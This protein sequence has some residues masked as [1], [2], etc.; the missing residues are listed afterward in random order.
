LLQPEPAEEVQ[1][2]KLK[3]ASVLLLALLCACA[4]TLSVHRETTDSGKTEGVDGI[5]FYIQKAHCVHETV[6]LETQYQLKL[7]KFAAETADEGTKTPAK[8]PKKLGEWEKLIS[9]ATMHT[10]DFDSLRSLIGREDA[11]DS[12]DLERLLVKLPVYD[13]KKVLDDKDHGPMLVSNTN[14]PQVYVDYSTTYFLN[15]KRP[16]IGTSSVNA[17][18]RP[19]G[20]L[21]KG[22]AETK[23]ETITTLLASVPLKEALT[24]WLKLDSAMY[25][26]MGLPASQKS[27]VRYE[28]SIEPIQYLHT[29]SA[30]TADIAPSCK[31]CKRF[32]FTQNNIDTLNYTRTKLSGGGAKAPDK[33]D[34]SIKVTGEITLPKSD[35]KSD[36]K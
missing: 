13:F 6:W 25:R 5:P 12:K 26:P 7:T 15:S 18:T 36:K 1:I 2:M 11:T 33:D 14:K 9:E 16:W 19:D 30:I 17:E 31:V 21:G 20:T 28:L 32:E 23:D 24:K 34:S 10:S 8:P 29:L 35:E 4:S 3:V 22:T 27:P